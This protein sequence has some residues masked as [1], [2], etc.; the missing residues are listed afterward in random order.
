MKTKIK[1]LKIFTAD[2]NA[3]LALTL[4]FTFGTLLHIPRYQPIVQGC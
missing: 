3:A 2:F 4:F 1:Q